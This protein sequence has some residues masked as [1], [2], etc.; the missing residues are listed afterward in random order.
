MQTDDLIARLAAEARPVRRLHSPAAR[1]LIWL[2]AALPY[3]TA[4]VLLH[5]EVPVAGNGTRFL[6]EQTATFATAITS[7]F[8]AFASSVPGYDRRILLL[9]LPPAIL[10]L[11]TVG[12]GCALDWIQ[13]G[14]EGLII[15][16]DWDCLQP[17]AL[18]GI[19]PAAILVL[20]LRRGAPLQPRVTLA[21]AGLATAALANLVLQFFHARDAS[22][23]VLTWH[24]GGA[25][26][27]AILGAA[28]GGQLLGWRK[29]VITT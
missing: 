16:P 21:F 15:R 18:I 6:L 1:S 25:A 7:V 8:A 11:A 12:Y 3:A 13:Y 22:I 9:P 20:M 4:I 19:L 29:A 17:A 2:A 26:V 10:W 23:M 5:G 27:L 24:L 28:F 14:P